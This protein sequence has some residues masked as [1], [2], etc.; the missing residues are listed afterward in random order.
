LVLARLLMVVVLCLGPARDAQTPVFQG[1]AGAN[2]LAAHAAF[3]VSGT[4]QL[5]G[6]IESP[7]LR[8]GND[9]PATVNSAASNHGWPSRKETTN[10]NTKTADRAGWEPAAAF[11][12]GRASGG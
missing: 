5:I 4:N 8:S 11:A 10:E 3:G 2:C 1:L 12:G 6:I 7:R 9:S